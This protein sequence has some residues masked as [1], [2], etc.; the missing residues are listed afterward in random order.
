M[1]SLRFHHDLYAAAAVQAAVKTYQPY[2]TIETVDEPSHWVV[3]VTGKS[4]GREK[5]LCRELANFALGL[6]IK[7]RKTS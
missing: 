1:T 3:H 5:R 2:G 7:G 4:E 6:T